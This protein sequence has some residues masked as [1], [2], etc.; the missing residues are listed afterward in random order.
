MTDISPLHEQH[1]GRLE[2]PPLRLVPAADRATTEQASAAA[3][4]RRFLA[5][6]VELSEAARIFRTDTDEEQPMRTELIEQVRARIE[7]GEYES[8][9]AIDGAVN[10][11]MRQLDLMA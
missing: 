2:S 4:D 3:P 9:A 10:G 11:I 7:A 6:S 1:N 5:D 8:E